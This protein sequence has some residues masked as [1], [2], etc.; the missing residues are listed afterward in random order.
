MSTILIDLMGATLRNRFDLH[1]DDQAQQWLDEHPRASRLFIA[2]MSSRACCSGARVCDV[3]IRVD[4]AT[5]LSN[6]SLRNAS[7]R[8]TAS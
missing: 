3:R 5:S 6:A 8:G 1:V 4:T 2:Y 7:R